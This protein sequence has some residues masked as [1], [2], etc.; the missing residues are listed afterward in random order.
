[1][2]RADEQGDEEIG[3]LFLLAREPG[4]LKESIHPV[5]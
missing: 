1:M 2:L 3:A 5:S 4:V